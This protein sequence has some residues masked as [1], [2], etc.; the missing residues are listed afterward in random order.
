VTE[1]L[2]MSP[3]DLRPGDIMLGPIGGAVGLGVGLGLL[4][5]GDVHRLGRRS[6][7]HAA[8]VTEVDPFGE[9]WLQ[10]V[11]AMPSG[12]RVWEGPARERWTDRHAYVRL[13]EDYAGQAQD[14]AAV[15]RLMV[16]EGVDYSFLSY[17]ALG[18]WRWG[19]KAEP[20]ERWLDR[21]RPPVDFRRVGPHPGQLSSIQLPCE[22]ICSVLVDQCWSLA[23]KRVM[24]G[25]ARQ[26]VTPGAL[27]GQLLSR[28]GVT[29]SLPTAGPSVAARSWVV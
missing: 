7:R 2:I 6:F 19:L 15:A 8:I 10:M 5:L 11:E 12:A 27:A 17:L 9:P 29:W 24:D 20:L 1:E 26:C 13:P 21:R 18:A 22:A 25:V 28:S 14:A 23:G 16:R 4:W 3:A